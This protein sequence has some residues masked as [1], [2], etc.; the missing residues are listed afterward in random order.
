M[1]RTLLIILILLSFRT[2]S[3]E[4]PS[5]AVQM[6]THSLALEGV[7]LSEEAAQQL[8]DALK[9]TPDNLSI[10]IKLLGYY[11]QRRFQS[12][13]ARKIRQQHVLWIIQTH[14]EAPIAGLPY[15]ALD[16][17]LDGAVYEQGA[18]LW[19]QQVTDH[20]NN[21]V[22]VGNAAAFFLLHDSTFAEQL[23]KTGAALEPDNPK[24]PGSLGHLYDL[25]S[26]RKSEPERKQSAAQ[27]LTAYERAYALTGNDR[28]KSYL[29]DDL[30][31]AAFAAGELDK[32]KQ[33]AEQMLDSAN[34]QKSDWDTGNAIHHGNLI[35]GRLALKAGDVDRAKQ[36]LIA[37]GK[38][39]GSPQL[40]SFGPNM[41]LAKELLE[42]GQRE[43]VLE[44][45]QLCGRF[46]TARNELQTWSSTVQ[47]GGIPDFGANL[48]Y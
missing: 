40:D 39:P 12:Q 18:K 38:T 32:A 23:L 29:L 14:P 7:K 44:Y 3:V 34:R 2:L 17:V 9:Q 48:D 25:G 33:Y 31:K 8:E 43:V 36:Y 35:L 26:S 13:S 37:A 6:D 47:Q 5:A 45:F 28:H 46:W 41:T 4:E 30:A 24:W 19:R 27:A 20:T 11:L 16:P 21:T 1:K 42:K 10:R 22:I 15:A